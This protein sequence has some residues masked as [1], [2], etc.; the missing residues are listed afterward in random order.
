ME[1][2]KNNARSAVT[3]I[4]M[5]FSGLGLGWLVGLSV[6]PVI[7][8][9]LTSLI[10]LVVSL[11]SALAGLRLS[12]GEEAEDAADAGAAPATTGGTAATTQNPPARTAPAPAR[13]KTL[14]S[15]LDPVP[16]AFMVF[17]L[18][19]GATFGVYART[20]KWLG[21]PRENFAEEWKDTGLKKEEITKRVFDSLYPP[22]S[23]DEPEEGAAASTPSPAPADTSTATT[24]DSSAAAGTEEPS[25]AS[26]G[27]RRPQ[28]RAQARAAARPPEKPETKSEASPDSGVLFTATLDQCARLLDAETEEALRQEIVP[29]NDAELNRL[30]RGC[31]NFECLRAGVRRKCRR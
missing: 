10:A 26:S 29:Y 28:R 15:L 27:N 8:I 12:D 20:H 17:A 3:L 4:C 30:A 13:R 21:A 2:G 7:Q 5:V 25:P 23:E 1:R 31:Q 6:S 16:V 24:N 18:A 9:I 11:S 14:P 22:V 19:C